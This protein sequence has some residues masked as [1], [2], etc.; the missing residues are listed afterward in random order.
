M[1]ARHRRANYVPTGT[2]LFPPD[3]EQIARRQEEESA[4]RLKNG[5]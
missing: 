1:I 2:R 3:L 5:C 4:T